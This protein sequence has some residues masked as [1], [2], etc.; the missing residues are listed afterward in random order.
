MW[1]RNARLTFYLRG[2]PGKIQSLPSKSRK[3]LR[4]AADLR[5]AKVH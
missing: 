1:L 3:L 5:K 4:G 2:Q